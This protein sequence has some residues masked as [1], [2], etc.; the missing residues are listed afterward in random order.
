MKLRTSR[1]GEIECG[2][3]VVMMFPDGVLGFPDS[4]R[5]ILLEHDAEGGPFKWLQSIDDPEL[6]FIVV[7]PFLVDPEYRFEIDRDTAQLIGTDE[8]SQCAIMGIIR[9]PRHAPEQ[10][11]INMKAPL[12]VNVQTRRGR[13][14]ILGS[15]LYSVSTPLVARTG[16]EPCE[17]TPIR[18]AVS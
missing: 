2:E 7:D 1:F 5:Y 10:M 13:Q 4:R 16:A 18:Q 8:T 11:T 3:E 14:I 9:V 6:A 12:V 15:N 17:T